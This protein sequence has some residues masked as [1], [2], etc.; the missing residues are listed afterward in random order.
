MMTPGIARN[1]TRGGQD[2]VIIGLIAQS[3]LIHWHQDH[4]RRAVSKHTGICRK[5]AIKNAGAGIIALPKKFS[6]R[7]VCL[8]QSSICRLL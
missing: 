4:R 3:E 7:F 8:V 1:E 2:H 6:R 5:F